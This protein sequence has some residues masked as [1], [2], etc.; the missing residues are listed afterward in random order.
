V[1][2]REHVNLLIFLVEQ[3]LQLAHFRFQQSHSLLQRFGVSS[4]EGAATELVAGLAFESDVCALRAAWADAIAAYLLRATSVAC[5]G[6]AS[7][8]A[9]PDFDH[10]HGIPGMLAVVV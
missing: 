8:T 9:C 4:R 10:F 3:V 2:A 1:H 6:D 7:L 5:L